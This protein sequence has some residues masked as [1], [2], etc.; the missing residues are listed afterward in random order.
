MLSY[1]IN[2]NLLSCNLELLQ[3]AVNMHHNSPLGANKIESTKQAAMDA[4]GSEVLDSKTDA[5]KLD[6]S[7]ILLLGPTGSGYY[8]LL[9]KKFKGVNL[10]G[11]KACEL[12]VTVYTVGISNIVT[13][14]K[15]SNI[16][17]SLI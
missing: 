14:F 6:K 8:F 3:M 2:T 16:V 12:V 5:V 7:N 15:K 17:K 13:E 10:Y 1:S 4:R 9:A 11:Y